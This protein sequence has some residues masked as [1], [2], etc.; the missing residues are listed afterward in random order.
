MKK[1][2]LIGW[3]LLITPFLIAQPTR[4]ITLEDILE[5][6]TFN[7]KSVQGVRWLKNGNQY[8][9]QEGNQIVRYD[10]STGFRIGTIFNGDSAGIK[11]SDYALSKDERKILLTTNEEKIYRRSFK[12]DYLVVD[13]DINQIIRVSNKGKQQVALL[14]PDGNKVA[15]VRNNNLFYTDLTTFEEV[16]LTADGEPNKIINGHTDWVYEEEFSFT[17]AFDWSPDGKKIAFLRFDESNVKDYQIQRWTGTGEL[18]PHIYTYKYPKA[19]EENARISAHILYLDSAKTTIRVNIDTYDQYIP[20]LKWTNN[21]DLL[22]IKKLNRLQNKLELI[23]VKA[24]TG[25]PITVYSEESTTYIDVDF[26][27]ELEYF[28]G[29]KENPDGFFLISSEKSGFKH[30]YLY[31]MNGSLYSQLTSGD[32]EAESFHGL[33]IDTKK[34]YNTTNSSTHC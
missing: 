5:K 30:F 7:Q 14:S 2:T 23:H 12:A 32:W 25:D 22:A 8:V 28:P 21:P 20:L 18:Y 26:C 6:G 34:Q 17:R 31:H 4:E 13:L 29:T 27:H 19:G 11:F 3:L 10:A 9:V 24:Q 16:Q 33:I 1:L 15:F